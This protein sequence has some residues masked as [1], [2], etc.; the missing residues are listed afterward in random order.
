MEAV[1]VTYR[2]VITI[3]EGDWN[4]SQVLILHR[5]VQNRHPI[6]AECQKDKTYSH[7]VLFY[8]GISFKL[9]LFHVQL[10][11]IVKL[12]GIRVQQ[13]M[14]YTILHIYHSRLF[15]LN[16]PKVLEVFILEIVRNL[17]WNNDQRKCVEIFL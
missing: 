11:L 3:L 6:T 2:R 7:T 1:A 14:G 10:F 9:I 4:A 17:T 15:L 8:D 12:Y 13:I 16:K 5:Q